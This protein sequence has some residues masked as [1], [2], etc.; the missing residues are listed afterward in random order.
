VRNLV[1]ELGKKGHKVCPTVVGD[2]LRRRAIACRRTEKGNQHI[3][4]DAQFHPINTQAQALVAAHEPVVSVN[5]KKKESVG[6]FKPNGTPELV[7]IHD[8]I[9]P[10]LS[11]AEP[12]GA[13]DTATNAGW[14]SVGTDHDTA[15]LAVNAIRRWWQRWEVTAIQK[16]SA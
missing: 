5:T 9:D 4:R 14:V 13:Y 7:N 1:K 11:L 10:K 6:N 3:D 12:N 16:P 2:L 8:F 15:A